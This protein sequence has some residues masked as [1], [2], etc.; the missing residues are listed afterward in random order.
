M[1]EDVL[2]TGTNVNTDLVKDQ[3]SFITFQRSRYA[4][5]YSLPGIP[6]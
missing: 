4:I 5:L 1:A 3:Q 2:F 6:A